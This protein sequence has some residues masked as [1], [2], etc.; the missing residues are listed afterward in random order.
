[1]E[2][3][4]FE[5]IKNSRYSP[6]EALAF[7]VISNKNTK[8]NNIDSLMNLLKEELVK[9]INRSNLIDRIKITSIEK[10]INYWSL[11]IEQVIA[12]GYIVFNNLLFEEKPFTEE[13]I[14]DMFVYVMRLYSPDNAV[15]FMKKRMS[16]VWKNRFIH[17][18]KIKKR[19]SLLITN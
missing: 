2:L 8:E 1:M 16:N 11:S 9:N 6:K 18:K 10:I 14:T 17:F 19:V 7:L 12:Y 4:E 3:K 5:K 13:K 15:E